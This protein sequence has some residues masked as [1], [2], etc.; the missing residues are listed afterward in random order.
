MINDP[1]G[2]PVAGEVEEMNGGVSSIME[3][4]RRPIRTEIVVHANR[5]KIRYESNAVDIHQPL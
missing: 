3:R 4:A 1:V 5:E 2:W